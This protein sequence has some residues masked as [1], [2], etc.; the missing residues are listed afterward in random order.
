MEEELRRVIMF[1][2]AVL[3]ADGDHQ[4]DEM[5][6]YVPIYD[7]SYVRQRPHS[8]WMVDICMFAYLI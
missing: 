6:I 5:C 1:M 3:V 2:I 8:D 4:W 7:I